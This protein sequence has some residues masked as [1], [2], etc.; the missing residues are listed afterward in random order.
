M[1][2]LEANIVRDHQ[3]KMVLNTYKGGLDYQFSNYGCK[4]E[5]SS[6]T[7]SDLY[8]LLVDGC[9]HGELCDRLELWKTRFGRM[10]N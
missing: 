10:V 2:L 7:P 4:S 5:D 1:Q 8:E 3:E 9:F 6:H